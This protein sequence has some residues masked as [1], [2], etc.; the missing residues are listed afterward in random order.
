YHVTY[1][2]KSGVLMGGE[3]VSGIP[4]ILEMAPWSHRTLWQESYLVCFEH[5][6]IQIELPAPLAVQLPG[7]VTVMKDAGAEAQFEIPVLPNIS[8][9]RKQA[10]NFIQVVQGTAKPPCQSQEALQDLKIALE[11]I[12]CRCK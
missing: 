8:A 10:M 9:M 12:K 6:Y 7:K 1:A 3:S 4:L 2:D 11:Y 5:A